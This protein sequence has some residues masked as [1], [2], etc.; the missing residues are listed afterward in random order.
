MSFPAVNPTY[1]E[2][3]KDGWPCCPNCE[4]DE[5]YSHL[6]LGWTKDEPPSVKD[7]IDSGMKCYRC[8]WESLGRN[9]FGGRC[10][11]CYEY[12]PRPEGEKDYIYCPQC[13]PLIKADA[14]H[15]RIQ[16]EVEA[17]EWPEVIGI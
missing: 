1:K 9:V 11:R 14:E 17:M 5:L 4:E 7:C 16:Y 15:E 3:R 8:S 10:Q 13:R 6:M 12:F 2:F